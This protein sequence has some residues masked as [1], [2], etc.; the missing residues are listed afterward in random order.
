M[1]N[2]LNTLILCVYIGGIFFLSHFFGCAS[3]QHPTGGPRDSV[4]PKILEENPK[5]FT[6]SFKDDE[7]N[8]EFNEYYKLVN[9]FKEISV[10]PAMEK[11]PV[12]KVKKKTLNIQFQEPL[13]DSTTYTINFGNALADYNEGNVLKN[14]MYVFATGDKIDSLSISG[15]VKNT[16]TKEGVLDATVFI[17]PTSQDSLFGKKRAS[18][19]TTTDSSGNFSLKYLREGSYNLYALKEKGGDKIYN[20]TNEEIGFRSDPIVL[21]KDTSGVDLE[22]FTEQAKEF[23]L[24]DRKIE[25]DARIS[26]IFNKQ[27]EKPQIQVLQPATLN[28]SKIT[29]FSPTNDTAYVW[30][31]SMEFDSLTVA[32]Q[33]DK[34][35]LDTVTIR[36][37]KRDTYERALTFTDNVSSSRL[38]PGADVILISSAPISTIDGKKITLLQDSIPVNGLR[39][40][41]DSL[42]TRRIIFKYPWRDEKQYTLSIAEGGLTG[43]FG[44]TNKPYSKQ[45]SKDSED[46]YGELSII[47]SVPDTSKSYII[48]VLNEEDRI[49]KSDATRSNITLTYSMMSI[50]KYYVRVVYDDNKNGKW[51]TGDVKERKQPENVSNYPEEISLRANFDIEQK[52][53][54]PKDE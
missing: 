51:D 11:A 5:N 46:N 27:L 28:N 9:E 49:I 31:Q 22:I 12:F 29:E 18:I 43:T 50:G 45:L 13:Q 15:N 47:V 21:T 7:I 23:R 16:L 14:Y 8:I 10:S 33:D 26:F 30:T 19:F 25:K 38:K 36:R 41:R 39:V 35:N 52:I 54:I 44:G 34:Q 1:R 20:S 24:L 53:S 6:T 40:S 42:S 32:F 2:R 3:I 4:A 48:Q 17:L 37:N